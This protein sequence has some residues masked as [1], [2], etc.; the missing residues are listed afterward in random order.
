M[1]FNDIIDI[2]KEYVM[3][4]SNEYD[5]TY[6]GTVGIF[7]SDTK[8]AMSDGSWKNIQSIVVDD[9]VFCG[10]K[11]DSIDGHMRITKLR[12][13]HYLSGSNESWRSFDESN[14]GSFIGCKIRRLRTG[15]CTYET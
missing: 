10:Y 8:V 14:F 3:V 11:S 12:D 1:I 7:G 4:S 9:E 6:T 5:F 2:S 15:T 13:D